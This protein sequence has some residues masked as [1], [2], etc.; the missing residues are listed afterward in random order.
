MVL[1][2]LSV[3]QWNCRSLSTNFHYLQQYI[4]ENQHPI[5]CLTSLNQN[6]KKLP[7]I[8]GYFYPPVFSC[9]EIGGKIGAAIYIRNDLEY[10]NQPS[11]IPKNYEDVYSIAVKVKVSKTMHINIVSAYFN[12]GPNDDNI[13]WLRNLDKTEKYI[14]TGDF[15]AH[16]PLWDKNATS[17]TNKK[18]V[19]NIIDSGLILLNNGH[20][21]R[22]PDVH[23]HKASAIDLTLISPSITHGY[24]WYI[25]TDNLGSDHLPII[26]TLNEKMEIPD[27]E[28]KIPKYRYNCADWSKYKAFINAYDTQYIEKE[29]VDDIYSHFCKTIHEAAQLSIPLKKSVTNSKTAGN[30]WWNTEC[31]E[32]VKNKKFANK[33]YLKDQ[34]ND[35]KIRNKK[36]KNIESNKKCAE[37]KNQYFKDYMFREIHGPVDMPKVWVTSSKMKNGYKQPLCQITIDNK[38]FPTNVEKAEEFASY[39]SN[40]SSTISLEENEQNRRKH[41]ETNATSDK[42]NTYNDHYLNASITLQ[43]LKDAI[44]ELSVK[45]SAVG[46]DGI[47]YTLLNNMPEKGLN[48]LHKI[49]QKCWNDQS[50]PEIWKTS[51]VLPILKTGKNKRDK[52]N[53]RPISLTSHVSKLMEKIILNRM[54]Y[55]VEKNNIIPAN[56]NGF[57]KGR[58]T[59]DHIVKLSNH[60]KL[61]FSKRKGVLATFFDVR[62]AYDR[63]WHHKLLLKLKDIGFSGNIL[64]FIQNFLSNRKITTRVGNSYSTFH[65]TNMGIPQGSIIS[66]LLF[67]LL[68]HDLPKV[69][70]NKQIE[71]AQYADDLALWMNVTIRKKTYI[72]E[73]TYYEKNYQSNVNKISDFMKN[74]G[75]E[76][77]AEKTN[78]ILFSN[79]QMAKQMPKISLNGIPLNYVEEVKFLGVIFTRKLCWKKH[80]DYLCQKA[81]KS[82]NLLRFISSKP[83]GQDTSVLI[84]LANALVRSRLTYGQEA[85]F[86]APKTYLN[87]IKSLDSKA[88]KIALGVPTHTKTEEVYKIIG[89]LPIDQWRKLSCTKYMI[90]ASANCKKDQNYLDINISNN[91]PK[92][93]QNVSKILPIYDYTKDVLDNC[94]VHLDQISTPLVYSPIP[95]WEVNQAEYDYEYT[96]ITKNDDPLKLTTICRERLNTK[97]QHYLQVY[98]DGSVSDKKEAGAGFTIPY[99]GINK[100]IYLG[101]DYSVFS[102]E[103]V[104]IQMALHFLIENN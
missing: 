69:I 89:I 5:L 12:K 22:I 62:K 20:A 101:K 17:V 41:E 60:I 36:I 66:P 79:C 11:P 25:E 3:F 50:L 73:I 67:N 78:L 27:E 44:K 90:R 43:E 96:D 58:S 14:I 18:F 15:N 8:Q 26:T 94:N 104:A 33:E 21:T 32:V 6:W 93:S 99:L 42:S 75:L 65:S 59:T 35:D 52:N 48:C 100:S 29:N 23:N 55:Y 1:E 2:N 31:E 16:S 13:N 95:T 56:Q 47:S 39:F 80:I 57:R 84:H 45:K 91:F 70:T 46:I 82:L 64:A 28:D 77:S 86:S 88:F 34:K 85:Y 54:S 83:W 92:R 38:E 37:V 4:S 102:A 51:I 98:T 63:V 9:K 103:L 74:N 24:E 97:Y 76:F 53:Y 87:K 72:R 30:I 40:I 81:F 49:I 61:Q 19:D 68:L 10:I 7:Q 71:V